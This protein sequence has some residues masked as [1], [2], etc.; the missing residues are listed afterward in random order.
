MQKR[1]I[2]LLLALMLLLTLAP[3]AM[4]EAV[5]GAFEG[6]AKGFAGDV[7]VVLTLEEGKITGASVT[8]AEETPAIG[9]VAMELMAEA[10]TVTGSIIDPGASRALTFH[11]VFFFN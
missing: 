7:K 1:I 6:T 11:A 8:G 4:A 9:G 5:S 2:S 3:A 10:M